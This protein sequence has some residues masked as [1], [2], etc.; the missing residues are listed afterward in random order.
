MEFQVGP[1]LFLHGIVVNVIYCYYYY[2]F[3]EEVTFHAF[4]FHRTVSSRGL[5]TSLSLSLSLKGFKYPPPP[6]SSNHTT[7]EDHHGKPY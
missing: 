1:R 5:Q 2:L 6:L 7:Q 3:C 4:H